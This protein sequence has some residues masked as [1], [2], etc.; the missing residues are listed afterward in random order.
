MR[1]THRSRSLR[2]K[3]RGVIVSVDALG[4]LKM[5]NYWLVCHV[6]LSSH[7]LPIR[8]RSLKFA[9][10]HHQEKDSVSLILN[11]EKVMF[12]ARKE[13]ILN[14]MSKDGLSPNQRNSL[15]SLLFEQLLFISFIFKT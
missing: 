14:H 15:S 6:A 9:L 1:S 11:L 4:K 8:E 7:L 13:V 12:L 2:S 10:M 5:R 3:R